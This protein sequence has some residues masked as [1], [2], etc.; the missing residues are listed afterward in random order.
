M[1]TSAGTNEAVDPYAKAAGVNGNRGMVVDLSLTD[2]DGFADDTYYSDISSYNEAIIWEVHVRDFSNRIS[3]SAYPGKYLAF[4]EHSLTNVAGEPAGID[5]LTDLGITHVHLQPVY[6]YATVDESSDEPQFNWGYDPKNYNVPEGSYSTDPYHG[7]V[8]IT[9]FKEMVKAVHE[10]GLGVVMD[11]VYNHTYDAASNFSAIVPYY[12]YRYNGS[13]QLSN[14]SGCGN[15]TASERVMF[16]KF[17][18]DSVTY[19]AKEYHID[20]FRFDLMALHDTET[21]QEIEKAV[22]AVNPYAV[23]YGE[24]WTGGTTT[25]DSRL[26]ASQANIKNVVASEGAIGAVAVFNDA[27]RDGLKGSVFDALDKGYINGNP[28]T[29]NANKVVFGLKG[30]E[31]TAGIAWTV[32]DNGVIN[33]MACHDNNTLW[34]KLL[35]SNADASDEE[36][37]AMYRLGASVLMISKGIPFFLAGEEMLRTKGGDHNSYKSSDAVNNIDWDALTEGSDVMEM[38]DY[39]K[40]LIAMRRANPFFM[41]DGVECEVLAGNAIYVTYTGED[42]TDGFAVVNPGDEVLFTIPDGTWKVLMNGE[43]YDEIVTVFGGEAVVIPPKSV[44]AASAA[45]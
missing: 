1:T 22:H 17:M 37:I 12:Y 21:M 9:E 31:K 2:P 27:I 8:R 44:L 18:V 16:R 45:E 14:G 23:I 6:D 13:G 15:E 40:A 4:T 10:A 25:L 32:P 39:Y 11:V 42:G 30:G 7:E 28:S 19:W 29:A 26:Q 33:Y 3:A 24:G 35:K 41:E 43:V 5:Y 36:R 34:D 38:R 20:G